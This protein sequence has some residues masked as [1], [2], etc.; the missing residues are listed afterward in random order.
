MNKL[1]K[2]C[3]VFFLQRH[4]RHIDRYLRHGMSDLESEADLAYMAVAVLRKTRHLFPS[5]CGRLF[6]Q[7]A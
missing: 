2:V 5:W 3:E 4:G 6:L 7:K 1:L